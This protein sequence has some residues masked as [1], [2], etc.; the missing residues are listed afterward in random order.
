MQSGRLLPLPYPSL[1]EGASSVSLA[2]RQ[3][4][5]ASPSR[6]L[7]SLSFPNSQRGKTEK[8]LTNFSRLGSDGLATYFTSKADRR[9]CS[10]NVIV[11]AAESTLSARLQ[12]TNVQTHHFVD[13]KL[14]I[15]NTSLPVSQTEKKP[16]YS[17]NLFRRR[18][19][20]VKYRDR[21]KS[22]P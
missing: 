9:R 10:M 2:D 14:K 13:S 19:L 7:S 4:H 22:G 12:S 3:T 1:S 18:K 16:S 17:T 8:Y 15:R 6:L 11:S 5:A 20:Y 21:L